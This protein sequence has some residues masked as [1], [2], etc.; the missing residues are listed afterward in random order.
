VADLDILHVLV[1]VVLA[2]FH[3]V[4]PPAR[5]LQAVPSI[6]PPCLQSSVT[7]VVVPIIWPGTLLSRGT[8]PLL[9]LICRDCLAAPGNMM[10]TTPTGPAA[11]N[12]NKNKTCYKCQQEGHVSNLN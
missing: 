5:H 9:I 8:S 2:E 4:S 6:L 7:V 12:L 1:Q 10:D 3:P 11:G